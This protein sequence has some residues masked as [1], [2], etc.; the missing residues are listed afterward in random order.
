[1]ALLL[2]NTNAKGTNQIAISV[3]S[4]IIAHDSYIIIYEYRGVS[5]LEIGHSIFYVNLR[6]LLCL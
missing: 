1:M 2:S 3:N 5:E 6:G 4:S